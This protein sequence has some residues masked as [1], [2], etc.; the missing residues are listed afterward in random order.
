MHGVNTV[1][2]SVC[3]HIEVIRLADKIFGADICKLLSHVGVIPLAGD[4]I[5]QSDYHTVG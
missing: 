4:T 2:C 5:G 1:R 3:R